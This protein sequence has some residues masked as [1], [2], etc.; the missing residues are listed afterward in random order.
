MRVYMDRKLTEK[1]MEFLHEL[2]RL[3]QRSNVWL[4]VEKD[5]VR[6]DVDYSGDEDLEPIVLPDAI[7]TY[8]DI[9]DVIEHDLIF[10][11]I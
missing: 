3:M 11:M 5:R 1:E 8:M 2:R 9:D 6:I 4:S 7:N 10:D